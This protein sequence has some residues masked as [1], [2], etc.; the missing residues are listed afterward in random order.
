[1]M[2]FS[3]H[4]IG[5]VDDATQWKK[6]NLKMHDQLPT[7]ALKVKLDWS[8]NVM[9]ERACPWQIM[10]GALDPYYCAVLHTVVWLEMSL[11]QPNANLLPY[12]FA[13]KQDA[14]V[15]QGGVKAKKKVQE[16]MRELFKNHDNFSDENGPLGTHSIRKFASTTARIKGASKDDKDVRGRWR[17]RTRDASD[18]YDSPEM[19]WVDLN[20]AQKLCIGGACAYVA[21]ETVTN[22]FLLTSVAP[23]IAERFGDTVALVFAQAMMWLA[24]S[25]YHDWM[26]PALGRRIKD[27]YALVPNSLADDGFPITK[28]HDLCSYFR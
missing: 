3:F 21:H 22:Q 16:L 8:K 14:R 4:L 15:P 28:F 24:Y 17:T 11:G 18:S 23:A 19:P 13:L 20:V 1:M 12:V 26:P 27:G 5:R 2:A 10:I 6:C 7:L 9:D 25:Q